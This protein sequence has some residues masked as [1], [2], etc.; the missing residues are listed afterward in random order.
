MHTMK[1]RGYERETFFGIAHCVQVYF[2]QESIDSTLTSHYWEERTLI[3]FVYFH[4]LLF[5]GLLSPF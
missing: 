3:W 1:E 5:N 2:Q 4:I